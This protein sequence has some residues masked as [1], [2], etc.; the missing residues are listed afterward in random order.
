MVLLIIVSKTQFIAQSI[1]TQ[2]IELPHCALDVVISLF[3]RVWLFLRACHFNFEPSQM[4]MSLLPIL[5]YFNLVYCQLISQYFVS[6]THIEFSIWQYISPSIPCAITCLICFCIIH[7]HDII[8][9][10]LKHKLIAIRSMVAPWPGWLWRWNEPRPYSTSHKSL[11][12]LMT[13]EWPGRTPAWR[14]YCWPACPNCHV[15]TA[16]GMQNQLNSWHLGPLD[17]LVGLC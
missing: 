14:R 15:S 5:G 17:G 10:T 2:S 1:I 11:P 7:G 16:N 3:L 6:Y 12:P 8:Y 4:I 13:D 9:Y